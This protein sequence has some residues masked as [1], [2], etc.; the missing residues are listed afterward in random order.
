MWPKHAKVDSVYIAWPV[1]LEYYSW[2]LDH[3]RKV[4]CSVYL[5]KIKSLRSQK[6]RNL[7]SR[8]P[9]GQ[10]PWMKLCRQQQRNAAVDLICIWFYHI[11]VPF[12]TSRLYRDRPKPA[13][14]AWC[15]IITTFSWGSFTCLIGMRTHGMVFVPAL[16]VEIN[17]HAATPLSYTLSLISTLLLIST[18]PLPGILIFQEV[19]T[20]IMGCK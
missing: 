11:H 4:H 14:R 12:S 18:L 20:N 17:I 3:L 9:Q 5:S 10:L 13:N 7:L 1:L 19:T 8:I 15:L 2:N 16:D 6:F